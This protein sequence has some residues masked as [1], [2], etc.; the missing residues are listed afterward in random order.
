MSADAMFNEVDVDG[1]GTLDF[2]EF[3]NIMSS[4]MKDTNVEEEVELS[5]KTFD[6]NGDDHLCPS[7][8]KKA[9][10][11]LGEQFTQV[12]IEEMIREADTDGSG[13]VDFKEF[14]AIMKD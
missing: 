11:M 2:L 5:F 7:D 10:E 8:L 4:R 3:V 14:Q 9:T 6:L 12:E 1:N 13:V